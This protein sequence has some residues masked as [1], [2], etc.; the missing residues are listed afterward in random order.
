MDASILFILILVA[1]VF[2]GDVLLRW[3]RDNR[4]RY[5]RD[6]DATE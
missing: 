5:R 3:R 6:D 4:W 2:A 1:A